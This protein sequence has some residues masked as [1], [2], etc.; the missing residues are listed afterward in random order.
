ME[1]HTAA[2]SI[3]QQLHTLAHSLMTIPKD[4]TL[5]KFFVQFFLAIP[6]NGMLEKLFQH[7]LS[8][9]SKHGLLDKFVRPG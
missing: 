6:K 4:G 9:I 7:P 1:E 2:P 8:A 5:E 3:R